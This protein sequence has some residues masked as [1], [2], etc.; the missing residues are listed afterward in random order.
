MKRYFVMSDTHGAKGML[1][2]ALDRIQ[3]GEYNEIIH[4][5]DGGDDVDWMEDKLGRR[6]T[7]VSGNC[8]FFSGYAKEVVLREENVKLML[9]HG[10]THGV[11]QG[12]D[13]LSY[14]AEEQGCAAA[15]YGHTHEAFAGYVGGVLL[16]NPGSLLSGRYAEVEIEGDNI[17]PRLMRI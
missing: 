12:L 15:F 4:L 7:A 9:C 17:R 8:D 10:H 2:L 5:G 1:L 14:H 6:L 11:K 13:R 16:L 3:D